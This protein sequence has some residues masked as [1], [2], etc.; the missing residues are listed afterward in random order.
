M[1][2][3][4]SLGFY[5][6]CCVFRAL[7][8]FLLR[9]DQTVIGEAVFHKLIGVVLLAAAL[10]IIGYKW[11]DIGFRLDFLIRDTGKGF[12]L[13]GGVFVLAYGIEMIIQ[14]VSG[15]SPAL[16]AYVTSYAIGGNRSLQG[17]FGILF[18][19][20][21]GNLINVIMEEGVFRGLLCKITQEK[22]SFFTACI[23]SSVLFGI[24]HIAQP[25]RNAFDGEQ[26]VAGAVMA[27]I[28]LVVTS[29]LLGIQYCM[30]NKVTG[31]VWASMAAHFVNNTTINLLHVSTVNGVDQLQTVRITIA[32]T[33][34]FIIVLIIFLITRH[35][36]RN[37]AAK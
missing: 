26:S 24:W 34:S 7:E 28:L 10:A 19:C 20:I 36:R 21:A 15:N 17:G 30:L 11:H 13:G 12:L 29:T 37:T 1:P 32:Q 27:G 22:H 33:V 14:T 25:I 3:V 23:F 31:S 6:V 18:F 8:Y 2:I 35:K 5:A 9:T 16:K 4:F